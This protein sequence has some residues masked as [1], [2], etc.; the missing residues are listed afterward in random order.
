[1]FA[2]IQKMRLQKRLMVCFII[3]SIIGSIS[4]IGSAIV[5][6]V[7]DNQY[8]NALVYEGFAQGDIGYFMA[9][10]GRVD[11]AIHDVVSYYDDANVQK[12]LQRYYNFVERIE[13]Y[14]AEIEA[15]CRTA[16]EKAF[17][18]QIRDLW[19]Q[20]YEKAES[21]VR[22]STDNTSRVEDLQQT[23]EEVL[24]PL[25]EDLY[26]TTAD[27]L[28]ARS[29]SGTEKS[30]ELTVLVTVV[31]G[32]VIALVAIAFAV[33]IL[34]GK[35]IAAGIANPINKC[36][37]RLEDI[38]KGDLHSPVPEVNTEDEVKD[39]VDSMTVTVNVLN[40]VITDVSWLLGE[41]S[42][43]KF[44]IVSKDRGYYV[45]DT[46]GILE[47]IQLI[48]SSLTETLTDIGNSSEQVAVASGQLAEGA[49]ALAE[50]ATDQASAIEELLAT[51]TEVT[52]RVEET[53]SNAEHASEDAAKVGK[54][55]ELSSEQMGHMTTAMERI[56]DTSKQIAEIIN[57][58]D[59][60]AAQTNLLSLNAAIEAAR[61]GEAGKGFAVVAEEIRELSNQSS[62]AANN[63]RALIQ[64]SIS[65]VEHGNEIVAETGQSLVL[66]ADGVRTIVST[67]E[68]AKNAMIY[69]ASAMEQINEGI[70]QIS[71]VVQNN[72]AT[73][74]EN[75]ATSEELAANA[76]NLNVM[77]AKFDLG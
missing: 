59:A 39:L 37:Q 31:I 55:T 5:I 72:S 25:Y 38:S 12:A 40:N 57:S 54:Q 19:D 32:A 21:A 41:M 14:L 34:I 22:M 62:I 46:K 51:V 66:V 4:G 49:T 61:A 16:E 74:E 2:K 73:A 69:Q 18:S 42:H 50:G 27:M 13:P 3:I 44:N 60:I 28:R 70:T 47:S 33:S 15:K 53:A 23:L 48:K 76:E 10:L 1:M 7:I 9:A 56:S 65:E 24:L 35:N 26:E 63:T 20:Y 17:Y 11:V 71:Q 75:S 67:V 29:A 6:K 36:V 30:A 58:I 68:A 77:I 8:T 64:T 52:D 43:G 45:G